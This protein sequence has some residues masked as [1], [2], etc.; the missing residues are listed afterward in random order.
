MMTMGYDT[1]RAD[2]AVAATLVHAVY[3]SRDRV[4]FKVDMEMWARIERFVK[5]SAKR[6]DT[7]A[8]FV[9]RLKPRLS[10]EAIRVRHGADGTSRD[11]MTDVLSRP[12][13]DPH[14]ALRTL[15][16]ETSLVVLLVRERIE[17]ERQAIA[18]DLAEAA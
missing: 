17:R 1:D 18:A 6:A 2:A 7:L 10:C 15:Y 8:N 11:F 5:S 9:E 3:G 13:C 16:R 12:P 4:R 14:A